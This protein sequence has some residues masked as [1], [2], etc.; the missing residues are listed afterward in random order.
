MMY[1]Y[2][3]ANRPYQALDSSMAKTSTYQRELI[4]GIA[5]IDSVL[6]LRR[7]FT[8]TAFL[9]FIKFIFSCIYFCI[10]H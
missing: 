5:S 3:V 9:N 2:D 4:G 1:I 10:V 7:E 8:P 6:L